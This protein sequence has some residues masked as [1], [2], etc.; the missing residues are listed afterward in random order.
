MKQCACVLHMEG[1][2]TLIFRISSG[3][4]TC[5]DHFDGVSSSILKHGEETENIDIT[6]YLR[7][8]ICQEGVEIRNIEIH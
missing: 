5:F 8:V 6:R 2:V 3:L 7:R 1:N 4:T